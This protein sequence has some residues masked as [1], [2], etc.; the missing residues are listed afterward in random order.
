MTIYS[1]GTLIANRYEVVQG[2]REK[3]SLAGGMGIV[4]F[5]VDLQDDDR[6]VALKTFKPEYLPNRPARDRFLREGTTW[7]NLGRHPHIVR[8]YRV[9]RIGDGREV[10]LVLELVAAAEGKRDASLRAWLTPGNPL[11][12][13]QALLFALH[14]VRG[15]KHATTKIPGLVHRDL[16]PENVLVGRDGNVRVTDFG[17]AEVLQAQVRV[18]IQ[19]TVDEERDNQSS[20]RHT[21]VTRVGV[22][23]PEY[24]APEQWERR[25]IDQRADIYAL[26]C[27]L[28][29]ML[30]GQIPV[31]ADSLEASCRLHQSGQALKAARGLPK[32]V[33]PVLTCCLAVS[34]DERYANWVELE[35]AVVDAYCVATGKDASSEVAE[36]D[37]TRTERVSSGWSYLNIGAAYY[38]ISK[39]D[40]AGK[41]FE[42]AVQVGQTEKERRLE[43]WALGNLGNIYEFSDV[44][45]AIGF[46]EQHLTI[47]REIDDSD[48]EAAALSHLGLAYQ[49]LGETHQAIAYHEQHL[50]I[51]REIGD[52]VGEARALNNLGWG[53]FKLGDM[54]QAI[55]FLERALAI[56][57]GTRSQREE[58]QILINLGYAYRYL[59]DAHRAIGFFKQ[60][61]T[62]SQ[63]IG[64]R[65]DEGR[66]LCGLGNVYFDL[67]EAQQSIKYYKKHLAI[68]REVGNRDGEKDALGN[69][70]ATYLNLDDVRRAIRF[71]EQA[72]IIAQELGNRTDEG[73]SLSNLGAAYLRL[74]DTERSMVFLKRALTVAQE[75]GDVISAA[76]A[77]ANLA[78]L[79]SKQGQQA[80]ALRYAEYAAQVFRKAGRTQHAQMTQ[81]L[82]DQI[83]GQK[84]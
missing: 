13:K 27:L 24:M 9:E 61:L 64:N 16:K 7:V 46:H 69:L 1:S 83:R 45:R 59:D 18:S 39:F 37:E 80:E 78:S 62:I 28:V 50:T 22:G 76:Q 66:A 71:L 42:R 26:G 21:Q 48:G 12:I 65:D 20:I 81:Q 34:P 17:L 74:G 52:W 60:A 31:K 51:V 33:E 79:L 29:E 77:S 82:L 72:L 44:R 41:Y 23:T 73:T 25:D 43:S 56:A 6:P 75:I 32:E 68:M 67:R 4:Y 54:H 70:G 3:P 35:E 10:Y 40:V 2:P 15:M 30:T 55:R 14:I 11:N 8:A 57:Q 38:D 19:P 36:P 63:E 47:A 49:N 58:G 84:Q 5:C 53:Y